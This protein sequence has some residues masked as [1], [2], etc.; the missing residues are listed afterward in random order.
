[1]SICLLLNRSPKGTRTKWWKVADRV[2][3]GVLDAYL[4]QDPYANVACATLVTE[5]LVVIAVHI[6]I[7]MMYREIT[8]SEPPPTPVT[9]RE[10][11][12][13][14]LSWFDLYD[15]EKGTVEESDILTGVKSTGDVDKKLG[16]HSQQDD[17]TI[18]IPAVT[19]K[20]LH[21]E[22]EIVLDDQW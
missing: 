10:Y 5:N 14:G 19:V 6:V 18:D 22:K 2:S 12:Q 4:S 15:Q 3:D 8:G 20:T 21:P 1:V 13:Y 11:A 9:A 7:S 17:A 16:F